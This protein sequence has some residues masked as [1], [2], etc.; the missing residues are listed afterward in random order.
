MEHSTCSFASLSACDTNRQEYNDSR[1]PAATSCLEKQ[2]VD[3]VLRAARKGDW[4]LWQRAIR[5]AVECISTK[6]C[7]QVFDSETG[8]R[9]LSSAPLTQTS[10]EMDHASSSASTTMFCLRELP[11]SISD[12]ALIEAVMTNGIATPQ[13][14]LIAQQLLCVRATKLLSIR[15]IWQLD[16]V[17]QPEYEYLWNSNCSMSMLMFNDTHVRGRLFDT[18]IEHGSAS[19]TY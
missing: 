14:R 8:D 1:G 18:T 11:A 13:R 4:T 5:Y 15:L 9:T 3:E 7:A 19:N 6:P 2:C 17:L 16:K 10:P 12:K